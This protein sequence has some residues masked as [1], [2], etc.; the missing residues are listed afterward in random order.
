M[1][2]AKALF[3]PKRVGVVGCQLASGELLGSSLRSELLSEGAGCV[4]G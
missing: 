1:T 4:V 2:W 3:E